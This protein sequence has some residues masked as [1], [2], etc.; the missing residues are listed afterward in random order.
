[1]VCAGF[2]TIVGARCFCRLIIR[3][4]TVRETVR[5]DE[6]HHVILRKPLKLSQRRGA[7]SEWQFKGCRSL[8]RSNSADG[9]SR[10]RVSPDLQP[11]K[12]IF[13]ACRS[14]RARDPQRWQIAPDMGRFQV[15]PGKQQHHFWRES[16]P[17][18]RRFYFCNAGSSFLSRLLRTGLQSQTPAGE[19]DNAQKQEESSGK[20]LRRKIAEIPR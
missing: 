6:I 3:G 19:C 9:G 8:R 12:E 4:I 11:D 14:L 15:V 17:P 18:V 20:T 10:L 2:R 7:G 5:H 13:P 16:H 1:M